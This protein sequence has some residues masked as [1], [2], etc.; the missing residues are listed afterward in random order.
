M[1]LLCHG[2][3]HK[4][5]KIPHAEALRT[6]KAVFID[7]KLD[8]N[9]WRETR[10]ILLKENESFSDIADSTRQTIVRICYDKL[11]LYLSFDCKD[12]DIWG[13]FDQRDQHLWTEEAV[14]VFID[15]DDNENDYV[16]IEVSPKNTL[17]DS[18][19]IDPF[20]IDVPAT[21]EFNLQG[22]RTAV[23]ISGTLNQRNDEDTSWTVEISVPFTDLQKSFD[24]GKI[25]D[26]IWRINFY[27][28]NRDY[29]RIPENYAWSPTG[30]RFHKPSVFGILKFR[31]D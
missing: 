15:T 11:N 12:A 5:N 27:R 8:E 18:Y 31:N 16:E 6:H 3:L 7:G 24:R 13:T 10:A 28:I 14:E 17:F 25:A 19:I 23:S 30:G 29:G 9:I 21:S 22:I 20:N 26:T 4:S 1:S 2:Q